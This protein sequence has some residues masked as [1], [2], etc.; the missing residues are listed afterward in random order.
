M[1]YASAD[2]FRLYGLLR[3]GVA[4]SLDFAA[5][6]LRCHRR[7]RFGGERR[8]CLGQPIHSFPAQLRAQDGFH[9]DRG[10]QARLLGLSG[11]RVGQFDLYSGHGGFP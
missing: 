8:A 3:I 2:F 4:P 6:F 10:E 1:Q 7:N 11:Q 9:F 5:N